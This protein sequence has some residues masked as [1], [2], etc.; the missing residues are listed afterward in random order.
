MVYSESMAQLGRPCSVCHHP[1]SA[2][3]AVELAQGATLAAVGAKFGLK[4]SA[5]SLHAIRHL[6]IRAAE[7]RETRQPKLHPAAQAGRVIADAILPSRDNLIG[8]L[9][10]LSQRVDAI[11]TDASAGGRDVIALSGLSEIR[12]AIT[13]IAR[14]AGHDRPAVAVQ[15]NTGPSSGELIGLVLNILRQEL[16]PERFPALAERFKALGHG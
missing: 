10:H 9:E 6:N 16:P 13:D 14:L 5:L 8:R 11:A 15:V 2:E 7:R 12:K 3:I 4:K 1:R